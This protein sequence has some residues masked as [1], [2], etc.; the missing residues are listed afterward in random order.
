VVLALF[1]VGAVQT[2]PRYQIAFTSQAPRNQQLFLAAGDGTNARPLVPHPSFD[3]NASFSLDGQWI[4]FTSTREGSADLFRVRLDGSG[5]ERLTDSPAF[6]DQAAF[7][8]NGRAIAFVS[9]RS[10]QADIWVLELETRRLVNVTDH[11]EGDFRPAWS[12]DGRWIAF[13]SDRD[14]ARMVRGAPGGLNFVA[15]QS[16]DIYVAHPDGSGVRR[17]TRA[18]AIAGTPSWS[19]DGSSILFYEADLKQPLHRGLGTTQILSVAVATG[20][21]QVLT[22]GEGIKLFPQSLGNG[23]IGYVARRTEDQSYAQNSSGVVSQQGRIAF[24]SGAEGASGAFDSPH[25]SR[26]G[27]RMVFHRADDPKPVGVQNWHSADSEFGLVRVGLSFPSYS[28]DGARIAGSENGLQAKRVFVATA[29]GAERRVIYELKSP[30]P[31]P[32]NACRTVNRP[33]WSPQGDR[34]AF[35][36]GAHMGAPGPAHLAT[37]RPDGSDLKMLTSGDRHD[38]LPSWSPDGKRLAFRTV[39]GTRTGLSIIGVERGEITPLPTGSDYDTFPAWSP[40]GDLISFT[41]KRDDDYE[42]YVI[43]PDGWGL[44]RLTHT[45]GNDAH[46]AWSPDGEWIAFSTSRQGFKDE[47]ALSLGSPQPYGEICVMRPDGSDLR[48]LTDNAWE[49]GAASWIPSRNTSGRLP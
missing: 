35:S 4:V 11:P 31:C 27:K 44:R 9:S 34:I 42:I 48:V 47:F 30:E 5:L 13:S 18:N 43:R 10:G 32:Q 16:T 22:S 49:E 21:R 7:S 6:D 36:V 8:P 26:D 12:P 41:S 2:Q 46:S 15:Q 45:R 20:E 23:R 19:R 37:I 17:V 1:S 3:S 33:V 40:R 39:T 14:S 29:D 28:P 38:G 24:T 25:W